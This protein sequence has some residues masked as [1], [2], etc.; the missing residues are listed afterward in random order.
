MNRPQSFLTA[1]SA[2]GFALVAGCNDPF[3]PI[4]TPTPGL[5]DCAASTEW[6]LDSGGTYQA[7]PPLTLFN[8]APHPTTE[9]PFYRGGWQNFLIATRPTDAAGTPAF[10]TAEYPTIDTMFTPKIPHSTNRSYLGDTKQAGKREILVDQNGRTLYYSIEVNQGFSDFIHLNKLETSTAIQAYPSD[11]TKKNLFFPAGL[12][13]IKAAWQQVD[14]TPQEIADQ[15]KDYISM[16]TSVPTMHTVVDSTGTQSIEENRD[17]PIKNVTVRLIA[18]HVVY[19]YPGHPEFIWTSFEHTTG[20]PD[21]GTKDAKRNGAPTLEG[22]NP[23]PMDPNNLNVNSVVSDQENFYLLYKAHTIASQANTSI[24]EDCHASPTNCLHLNEAM[25]KFIDPATNQP[26][27]TSIYRMFP[28]SKSNTTDADDAITSLNH[29]VEALF[30][31]A[32]AAQQLPANDK[33]RFY[34]LLG[35]QWMDQPAYFHNNFPIQNDLTSPYAQAPG[36]ATDTFNVGVGKDKFVTAIQKE[37]SD[38]PYSILAGE[39]RMSSTSM[40]SFT[41]FNGSFPNCFQCHNTLG[42]NAHGTTVDADRS[43]VKLLDPGLLNVSHV[44]SEFV[45]EDCGTK[46]V[47]NA[48]GSSRADCTMP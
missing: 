27:Q 25:Q 20:T 26:Q 24:P 40:E 42:I 23:D 8:P 2:L 10:V 21:A 37:G 46:I 7:T 29:N 4:T 12:V 38:S 28:A 9:C 3:P 5:E 18:M 35:G 30:G 11:N 32:D 1:A 47:M 16:V 39:D 14:G 13:E 45:L 44:I 33:R 19:T 22:K 34:R 6:I 31:M 43:S 36:G 15:T 17:Q 48:D 41:Q